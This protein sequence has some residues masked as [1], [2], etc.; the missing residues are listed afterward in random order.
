[1]RDADQVSAVRSGVSMQGATIAVMSLAKTLPLAF[2][3][4]AAFGAATALTLSASMSALQEELE[5]EQRVLA[6]TAFHVVIRLGLG[7]AAI[8]AGVA[9]DVVGRLHLPLLG[10]LE[11]ARVVL[12]SA[13]VLVFMS[14][15]FV[16][17]PA[18]SQQRERCGEPGVEP[19]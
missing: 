3:G 13:G 19:A 1:M 7:I 14:R 9:A 17:R 10:R 5:G 18:P 4:A 12:A 11:P 2:I 15:A 8:S 16:H 6:F